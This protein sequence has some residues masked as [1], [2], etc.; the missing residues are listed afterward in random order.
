MNV[1]DLFKLDGKVA[2]V[3]GGGQGI[4]RGYAHALAQA[5]A[6]VVIAD[7]NE[8]TGNHVCQEIAE[9]G[10]ESMFVRCD[11]R[12]KD[13][14]EA[15]VSATVQRF[16]RLD[17]GV[18]N[19]GLGIR[20]K[21]PDPEEKVTPEDWQI[22]LDIN[23]TG[24][25][26]C[27]QAEANQMIAQGRGKIVNTASMSGT[28]ANATANYNAAK[29][30]VVML[31]KQLAV[32]WG[33]YNI[34]ANSISPTYLLSP[35]HARTSKARRDTMRSLHPMGWLMRPEDLYGTIVFLASDASNYVTGRDLIVDGGHTL[36]AW[37]APLQRKLPP[38]VSPEEET[39]S[40]KHDLDVLGVKYDADGVVQ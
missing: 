19:A 34:N 18:N 29:A 22:V 16:G 37:L 33:K 3:T 10:R 13:Q 23:L 25:F 40:L 9:Y 24:V 12:R 39:V 15:M 14:V 28:I 2:L 36:N 5:G 30:G 20:E 4:G 7:I 11:V 38:L 21:A 35:M 31:T 26:Y 32:Q 27:C 8:L 17:I 6:N 1:L